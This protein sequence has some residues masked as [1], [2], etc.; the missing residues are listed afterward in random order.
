MKLF[1]V[2]LGTQAGYYLITALW[3]IID[4]QSFM[5]VSGYKEDVWLVKTVG[6]LLIPISLTMI[7]HLLIKTDHR[8]VFILATC[9]CIAFM[10]I[11]LYYVLT[12]VILNIYL[13][14]AAVQ[15]LF[16]LLWVVIIFRHHLKRENKDS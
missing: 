8:P 11:D 7:A 1:R 10:C 2:T 9:C 13:V 5:L 15:L 12:N 14:D 3:P 6:A 16:L 4:I